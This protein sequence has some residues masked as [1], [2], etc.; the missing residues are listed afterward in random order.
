RPHLVEV[1]G[2]GSV[3]IEWLLEAQSRAPLGR[4]GEKPLSEQKGRK[5][6]GERLIVVKFVTNNVSQ[7]EFAAR[8][9]CHRIANG[10]AEGIALGAYRRRHFGDKVGPADKLV[11]V[12]V[13]PTP[14]QRSQLH[15]T[16]HRHCRLPG[17]NGSTTIG[18]SLK[19]GSSQ[20]DCFSCNW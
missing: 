4:L 15:K 17:A 14:H 10:Q 12:T 20:A 18:T 9:E 16:W 11:M 7:A 8:V 5:Y 3:E 19:I 6:L 13:D 1:A 2:G